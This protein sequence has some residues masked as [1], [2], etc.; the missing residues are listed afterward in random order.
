MTCQEDLQFLADEGC[1]LDLGEHFLAIFCSDDVLDVGDLCEPNVVAT[2]V[3]EHGRVPI[4]VAPTIE[5]PVA[6]RLTWGFL[7]LHDFDLRLHPLF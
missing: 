4:I 6:R 3:F 5:N 7:R 1:A 2:S